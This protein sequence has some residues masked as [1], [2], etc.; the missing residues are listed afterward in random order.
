MRFLHPNGNDFIRVRFVVKYLVLVLL[1]L[2]ASP[3]LAQTA[4]GVSQILD[5]T[6]P[7][8][9]LA[10]TVWYP[11]A[12]S[13]DAEIAGNAVFTGVRGVS[14]GPLATGIYPL[15]LVSHGGLR[16]AAD[17]GAWLSAALARAGAITVEISAPRP[18]TAAVA[19]D[20]IWQRPRDISRA[21]DTMLASPEWAEHIDTAQISVVGFALGGTASLSVAGAT[22]DMGRYVQ[23]CSETRADVPDCAWF[24]AQNVALDQVD[25]EAFAQPA[26]DA[27]ISSAV[28]ISTEYATALLP[29]AESISIPTLLVSLGDPYLLPLENPRVKETLLAGAQVSD[30]FAVCTPAGATILAEDGGDPALCATAPETRAHIHAQIVRQ[31]SIFLNSP[32]GS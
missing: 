1:G 27:R 17:S 24:A 19:V 8:R 20:E 7:E 31:I 29:D 2:C 25:H 5:K 10:L 26:R 22:P 18:N 13:T 21:L 4:R 15:V 3:C 30:A 16:S 28:A 12:G 14:D 23:S 9:P 6:V 11:S 32:G